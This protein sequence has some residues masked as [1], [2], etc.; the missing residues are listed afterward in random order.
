MYDSLKE[1]VNVPIMYKK[2]VSTDSYGYSTFEDPI[3]ILVYVEGKINT[4]VNVA[5][6]TVTSM[7]TVYIDN[8]INGNTFNIGYNDILII[9]GISRRILALN[10]FF[11]NAIV[12]V[13]VVYI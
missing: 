1:L 2:F 9:G 7:S 10:S 4:V 5:G 6:E 13:W 3:D 11:R 8:V 12:D